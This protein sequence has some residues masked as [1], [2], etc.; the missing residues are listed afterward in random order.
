MI[1]VG[2]K[3]NHRCPF[4]R[5]SEGASTQMEDEEAT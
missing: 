3:Y 4:K 1:P 2:P 5:E